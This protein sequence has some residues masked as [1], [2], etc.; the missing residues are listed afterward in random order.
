[1]QAAG[2]LGKV[3]MLSAERFMQDGSLGGGSDT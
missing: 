1:V 2:N 3:G